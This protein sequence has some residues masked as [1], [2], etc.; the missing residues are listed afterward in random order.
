[1]KIAIMSDIHGN[2]PAFAAVESDIKQWGADTVIVNGDIINRGP[3]SLACWELAKQLRQQ[4]GWLIN[5]GNHEGYV[6]NYL[7]PSAS[8]K[9]PSYWTFI[10]M[11][12]EARALQALGDTVHLQGPDDSEVRIRHGSMRGWRDGLFEDSS[13]AQ[14]QDQIAP[15]PAVFV[16]SHTHF[17][18]VKRFGETQVMNTGSAGQPADGD[19]A[20]A[21]G[22][23]RWQNGTWHAEVKRVPYDR[24]Q[25]E[26]DFKMSGFLQANGPM[27]WLFYYEWQLAES[28]ILP[29]MAKYLEPVRLGQIEYGRAVGEYLEGL[30]F[31]QPYY[32]VIATLP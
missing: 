2:Y 28:I 13:L 4:D 6:T 9:D 19:A 11:G 14:I 27:A 29:W 5:R 31:S 8:R 12:I 16:T 22:R 21:Y 25:T 7:N 10:Q 23:L 15:A 1:M 3:S 20:A 26:R 24:Q 30:G 32:P 18:F 17:A